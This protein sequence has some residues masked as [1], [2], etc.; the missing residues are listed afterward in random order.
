MVKD[1]SAP[2]IS[3]VVPVFNAENY[4]SETIS[5]VMNQTYQNWE[6]I[7]VNDDSKDNS[8]EIAEPF[9][10]DNRIK[11]VDL[12]KNSGNG[13]T[14]RNKGV[15]LAKGHYIAFL[16]ADDL[17]ANCKLEK[18][19]E[20]MQQNDCPFSFTS[21]EFTDKKGRPNGKKAI[22]PSKLT[23]KQALK[24]TTIFTSTV[25][26][27]LDKLT[28]NDIKMP[29][30]PSEDTAT[31]WQILKKIPAGY[32]MPEIYSYYRRS[33]DTLSSN[34]VEAIR[35]IWNLYRKVEKINPLKSSY[36]FCFYAINAVRR[37]V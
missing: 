5:T 19:L 35:R 8:K 13:A 16:D 18:Q 26:L 22:V 11:W 37:R 24:N 3:I 12:P 1:S 9:L 32:G 7:L 28:K 30:V 23:Y 20:F 25:M 17:W 34:K 33:E 14:P 2:L 15:E 10:K 31:W 27:D 36:Y 21:Y 6:L 29:N 4:L